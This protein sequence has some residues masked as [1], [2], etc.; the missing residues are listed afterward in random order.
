MEAFENWNIVQ[1]HG[2][3]TARKRRVLFPDG[4]VP[5]SQ[6]EGVVL[7]PHPSAPA[8]PLETLG[9]GSRGKD[10]SRSMILQF[11]TQLLHLEATR[12][13]R[14]LSTSQPLVVGWRLGEFSLRT[15][16]SPAPDSLA[17]RVSLWPCVPAGPR[18]NFTV[19]LFVCVSRSVMSN[20]LQPHRL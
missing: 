8:A 4:T 11:C 5:A 16:T 9:C 17:P 10:I 12:S 18:S 14:C 6:E 19:T 3:N 1:K 20:S 2:G 15:Q 7:L 13:F